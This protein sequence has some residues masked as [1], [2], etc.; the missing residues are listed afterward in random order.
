MIALLASGAVAYL[1]LKKNSR[2]KTPMYD[3]S[4]GEKTVN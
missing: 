4:M 1:K 3:K 2:E